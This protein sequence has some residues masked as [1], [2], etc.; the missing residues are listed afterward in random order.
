MFDTVGISSLGPIARTVREAALLLDVL[1]GRAHIPRQPAP[2]SF[3]AAC[4]PP[5]AGLRIK[6]VRT[7]PLAA[8]DPDIDAAVVAA[9]R[10][11]ESLGHHVVEAPGLVGD[12]DDFVPI[13]A[14]LVATVPLLPGSDRL[15]QPTTRW[16]RGAGRKVTARQAGAVGVA[17]ARR[18]TEWFG[19]VDLVLTPTVAQPPPVVGSLAAI[20]DDG[21]AVFR[22]LAPIGAFTAPFNV[23][24]QPAISL[25]A[26]KTRAGLPIG[27]QLVGRRGADRALLAAATAL[28]AALRR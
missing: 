12:I 27:I 11:L 20:A 13:M 25:P 3:I 22:A 5:P 28:E 2:T 15:L 23:S 18:V 14:Q 1:C 21:E 4:R 16:L 24:G 7:T 26:G 8:V 9:A 6:L 10:A 19:D 17:L